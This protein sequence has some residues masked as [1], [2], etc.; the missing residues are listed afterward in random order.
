M[1]EAP[2][3][4]DRFGHGRT[5]KDMK[6]TNL[7]LDSGKPR[8]RQSLPP[9]GLNQHAVR[10][11]NEVAIL[12]LLHVHGPQSRVELAQAL[13]L[14]AK[15]LTNLSRRLMTRGFVVSEGTRPLSG[16]G[17]PREIL[18]LR[19]EKLPAIGLHLEEHR[20]RAALVDLDGRIRHPQRH[21]FH[22][23]ESQ[24]ELVEI[25]RE[26]TR[27]LTR[28]AQDRAIGL[29]MAMPGIIDRTR[30]TVRQASHLPEWSGVNLATLFDGVYGG[31]VTVEDFTRSKA[32]AESWFGLGSGLE[33]FLLVDVGVG[34]GSAVV[35]G[36][37]L[38]TGAN[39]LAG[40]IGHVVIRAGGRRC[41]CGR[42]GCLETEASLE[43]MARVAG[44]T[45]GEAM[46]PETLGK[47]VERLAAHDEAAK[48][49]VLQ[50]AAALGTTLAGVVATLNPSHVI[51][52]GDVL[53]LE[54]CFSM[55]LRAALDAALLPD[56]AGALQVVPSRLGDDAALLGAAVLG[57]QAIFEA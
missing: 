35:A 23:R 1:R 16:R 6:M 40:E 18:R 8:N 30:G 3:I 56:L 31:S 24:G 4:A 36:G 37:K 5:T 15:T 50:A 53:K 10:K 41:R 45:E 54:P 22:G 9:R 48:Q 38:Q 29:G 57:L 12:R 32:L 13:G 2:A 21:V 11:L 55:A 42:H 44:L 28:L 20:L 17:R 33:N 26:T 25:V 34:I 51:V 27:E 14:D 49:A 39:Q 47:L 52:A 43:A 7:R 46:P 19:G